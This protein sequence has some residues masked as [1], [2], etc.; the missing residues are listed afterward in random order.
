MTPTRAGLALPALVL[1]LSGCGAVSAVTLRDTTGAVA[2]PDSTRPLPRPSVTPTPAPTPTPPAAPSPLPPVVP[3]PGGWLV[4]AIPGT[5][6]SEWLEILNSAGAVVARTAIDPTDPWMT[7]S[8]AGGAYWAQDGVE[9]EL[10]PTGAVRTLGTIPGNANGVVIGPDGVSYAYATSLTSTNGIAVNKIVV[11]RPGAA[12]DV[13]ADRV[14][15]PNHPTADAPEMWDYYLMS[16]TVSG[17]TFA[18]VP[19]GGCGCGSFDMQMQSAFSAIINP[20]SDVVTTLT[21]DAACPLSQV[22]SSTETVCFGSAP[23]QEATDSIQ[24]ASNGVVT[25]TY[26]LSGNNLAGDAA[27]APNGAALAY[28]TI[29]VSEDGCGATITPTLRI[30]NIAGGTAVTRNVGDFAPSVWGSNGLLYGQMTDGSNNWLVAVNP[31]TFVVTR[32]TASS[33]GTEFVGIV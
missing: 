6:S 9:H 24:I 2:L 21:A 1:F 12:A 30:L 23:E 7:A 13:I 4:A 15:D 26:S 11:V 5:G 20:S 3:G 31:S 32:L 29:P 25:H 16:W 33:P 17:I 19:T 8:G 14:S 10:T 28:I 18:R 22:G 27:F